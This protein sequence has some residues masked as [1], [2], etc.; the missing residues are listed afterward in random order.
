MAFKMKGP[1][2][3]SAVKST[4]HG[5]PDPHSHEEDAPKGNGTAKPGGFVP[6]GAT[7][8]SRQ[9]LID[10]IDAKIETLEEQL[11]AGEI[12]QAKF[13]TSRAALVEKEMQV[14]KAL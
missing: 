13:D 6:G 8:A 5:N 4:G 7:K 12:T 2:L 14:K 10:A 11:N 1:W 3:K 9:E